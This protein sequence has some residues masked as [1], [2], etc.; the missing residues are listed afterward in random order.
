MNL[1]GNFKFNII[2]PS[3]WLYEEVSKS[4]LMNNSKDLIYNG[5]DL[6]VFHPQYSNL[7][8]KY[9]LLNKYVILGV[10]YKWNKRKGID[11]FLEI[12]KK[13]SSK[14]V[15]LLVGDIDNKYY[16]FPNNIIWIKQLSDQVKLAEL[17]TIAEVF[18]E[19]YKRRGIRLS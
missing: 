12:S 16:K 6:E 10:S 8:E 2:L 13:I 7:K 4:F 11:V 19:P 1:Y 15:I 5:I 9:D 17:Y 18:L 14:Y 3:K